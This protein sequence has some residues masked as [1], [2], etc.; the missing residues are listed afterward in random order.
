M[1]IE[2]IPGVGN[3]T[4]NEFDFGFAGKLAIFDGVLW[5]TASHNR[6]FRRTSASKWEL[7]TPA[8]QQ[9]RNTKAFLTKLESQGV[10]IMV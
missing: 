3:E 8:T 1:R 7:V 9:P 4:G 10:P 2:K 5:A 6:I